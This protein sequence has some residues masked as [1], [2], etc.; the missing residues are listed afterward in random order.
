MIR[1]RDHTRRSER[2][3]DR[4]DVA[5]LARDGAALAPERDLFLAQLVHEPGDLLKPQG[6]LGVERSDPGRS[7]SPALMGPRS[8]SV[9]SMAGAP[10]GSGRAPLQ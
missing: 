4:H 3:D 7:P 8:T 1:T 6:I 9:T 2:G 10:G 5:L